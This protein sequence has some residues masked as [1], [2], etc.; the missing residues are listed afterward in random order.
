MIYFTLHTL[1]TTEIERKSRGK[2]APVVT[3]VRF[4]QLLLV[5]LESSERQTL[6]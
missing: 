3:M 2:L 6:L 4:Q 1:A 5:S